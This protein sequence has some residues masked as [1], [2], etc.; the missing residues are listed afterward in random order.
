[1]KIG[2]TLRAMSDTTRLALLV[3]AALCLLFG[4]LGCVVG[5]MRSHG[6]AG[7]W[8]GFLLGPIGIVVSAL[9]PDDRR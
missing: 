9:L 5:R 6:V 8:L 7:F 3:A 1:M 2:F 4:L